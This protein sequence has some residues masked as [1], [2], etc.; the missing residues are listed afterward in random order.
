MRTRLDGLK[1]GRQRRLRGGESQP[2]VPF[3]AVVLLRW[4]RFHPGVAGGAK[5]AGGSVVL[6]RDRRPVLP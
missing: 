3:L 5:Q 4:L 6:L 2:R 1:G